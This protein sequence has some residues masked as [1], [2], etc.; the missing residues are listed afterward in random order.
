M[1][2]AAGATAATAEHSSGEAPQVRFGPH[3]TSQLIVR[4]NPVSGNSHVSGELSREMAD[5]FTAANVKKLLRECEQAGINAWQS[6]G[7][8][9]IMRLL[10][11]CRNEG[12]QIQ[13]IRQTGK[14]VGLGTHIPA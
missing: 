4:G 14:Q 5:Y 12:G 11:E 6:R 2:A 7:D 10:R 3:W 8:R 9:H 1:L 13:W